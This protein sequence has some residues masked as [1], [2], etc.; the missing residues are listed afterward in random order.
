M[1]FRSHLKQFQPALL[2]FSLFA[3]LS[4][5]VRADDPVEVQPDGARRIPPTGIVIRDTDKTELM[6]GAEALGKRIESLKTRLKKSPELL[7][8]LPDV[9][10][11]HNAARYGVL[12]NEFYNQREIETAKAL[13]KQGDERASQLEKGEH[14]WTAQ[15]GLVVRGYKSKIDGSV[16]PFGL[17][18]PDDY[19]AA[20]GLAYRL[21]IWYHGRG[22]NLTETNFLNEHQR[23]RGEFAPENAIVLHPYGR[24]CNA[25]KFA[26]EIDTFEA[27]KSVQKQ[28]SIDDNRIAVRGFSMGGAAC[29]QFATHFAGQWAAAAPGAGFSETP[30]FTGAFRDAAH[31]PT[32]Y[33]QK[34]WRIYDGVD[35]AVNLFNCPTVAYSGEVDGQ[36]QAAVMME[37]ALAKEGMT[38]NHIIG[39]KAQHFYE[40]GAKKEVARQVDA[41]VAA[42]RNNFPSEVRFTTWTLRYD[43]MKWVKLDGMEKHW[44]RARLN[45]SWKDHAFSVKT[46]NA[47]AFS[48]ST[49]IDGPWRQGDKLTVEADGQAIALVPTVGQAGG[50]SASFRKEGGNWKIAKPGGDGKLAKVHG[51]QGPIDDAFMDSF[52]M[53]RPTGTPLNAKT[54]AWVKKEMN[55]AIVHW[56]RTYRGEAPVRDDAEVTKA[57][58]ANS[59]LI[60]WG[61]PG[62]NSVLKKILAK[63]PLKWD[64]SKLILGS[65]SA[66]SGHV[67]P[68]LIYPNP[69]NPKK[70]VV[71]NSGFTFRE[72]AYENNARQNA[73]LP[74]YAFVDTDFPADS[75]WPGKVLEA[76]FFGERWE[77]T[78]K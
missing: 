76:G 48:I 26:G 54:D 58:I 33:E 52:V 45:A 55:H 2:S 66:D 21:D 28:Y 51:L 72:N 25:N 22:E 24:Y 44:E 6:Q 31:P 37:N 64:S 60:L 32:W 10:I 49:P 62:S 23:S 68:V 18:I 57:D 7:A 65:L 42:G 73:K 9:Q 74:D 41:L 34:L 61:D 19:K 27:L 11:F 13:L 30:D 29:W 67:V 77:T 1:R 15:T 69:L 36:R 53:V 20:N 43:T 50:F 40:A 8:L 14:P 78:G 47:S 5:G 70:Y 4:L 59:N 71:L 35:Y 63:L 3:G 16:Q 75:R 38:L 39:P 56:R 17:V 46:E 12:Y